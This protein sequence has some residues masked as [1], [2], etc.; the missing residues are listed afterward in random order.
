MVSCLGLFWYCSTW[1]LFVFKLLYGL[2]SSRATRRSLENELPNYSSPKSTGKW[3]F[4]IKICKHKSM[5]IYWGDRL[6][7]WTFRFIGDGS[8][9]P[10]PSSV[11]L[12]LTF[13][14]TLYERNVLPPRQGNIIWQNSHRSPQHKA[15]VNPCMYN[16]G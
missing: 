3:K 4:C 2:V 16:K 10:F 1:V 5:V 13:F 6:G 12:L 8:L 15:Y 11:G 14:D 9:L 7:W